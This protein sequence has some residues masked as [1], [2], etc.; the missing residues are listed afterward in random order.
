MHDEDSLIR[1]GRIE[2]KV[3]M[4][5]DHIKDHGKRISAVETK[6]WWAGGAMAVLGAVAS[7]LGLPS[8]GHA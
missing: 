4:I 3:D 5:L 2:G 1:L 6:V 7:K 8:L